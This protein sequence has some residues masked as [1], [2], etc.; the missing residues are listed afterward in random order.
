MK[1][2]F[3]KTY[4]VENNKRHSLVSIKC[5]EVDIFSYILVLNQS[6][7]LQKNIKIVEIKTDVVTT[8]DNC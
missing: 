1:C 3:M 2:V 6:Q 8:K 7:N 5:K 4:G